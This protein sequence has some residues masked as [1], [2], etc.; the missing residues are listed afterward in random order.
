MYLALEHMIYRIKIKSINHN[1]D[2]FKILINHK[3]GFMELHF[4]DASSSNAVYRKLFNCI[5]TDNKFVRI[6]FP[7]KIII[8]D[9]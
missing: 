5:Q 9:N 1:Y 3:H 4:K 2:E 7:E 6:H 8:E